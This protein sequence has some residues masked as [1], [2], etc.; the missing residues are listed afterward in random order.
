MHSAARRIA[1]FGAGLLGVA[2][3]AATI[4]AAPAGATGG[5]AADD[6][7]PPIVETYDYPGA[8]RIFAERNITLLKGDG[9]VQL[10]DCASGGNLIVVQSYKT[11][12]D[13][14]FRVLKAPGYVTMQIPETYFIM[15]DTHT[16]KATLTAKTATETVDIQPGKWTPVGESLPNH[17]PAALLEIRVTA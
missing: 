9:N 15:G 16:A 7:P 5:S 11:K 14:C 4:I 13:A 3:L 1:A 8:A 6:T 12:G 2:A 10:A 17:D